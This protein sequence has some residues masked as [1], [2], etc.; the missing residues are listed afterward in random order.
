MTLTEFIAKWQKSTLTERA[1]AQSHFLELCRVLGQPEPSSD[2]TGENYA[3][4]KSVGKIGGKGSGGS[5]FA[6]VWLRDHFAWE[7]KGKRKNLADAYDQILQYREQLGNPPLLVVCDLNRFE[8]H[9]NFTAT[10]KQI[11]KF[12][13]ADLGKNEPTSDCRRPP[14][15]VLRALFEKPERLRPEHTT[16]YVTEEAAKTFGRLAQS[17]QG[18]GYEPHPISRFLIRVLFCLFAEDVGLL[19][20]RLFTTLIEKTRARPD[21]F[22]KRLASLFEAMSGGGSFGADDIKHF[23]GGL[24]TDASVLPLVRDDLTILAGCATLDWSSIEPSIFGTLFERS[25]DPAS[26]AQLGAHYTSR[27]DIEA[28]VE[29]V[30]MA[31]LRRRWAEVQ[32]EASVLAE[33]REAASGAQKTRHSAALGRLLQG[34]SE[35]LAAVRVLDPACGSGNFLYVALRALLDLEKDVITHALSLDAG[36]FF[37]RVGPEQMRGI[38]LNEYAHELAPITVWIG[39]IQ[40]LKDNGFGQPSEPILREMQTIQA[41]DAVL[42]YDAI[43]RPIEP[44]WPEADVIIGNPPFLG[45]KRMRSELGPDYSEN[46]RRLYEGRVP[47]GADLVTYWFERTRALVEEGKVQRAGLLSTNSIRSGSNRVVLERIKQSGDIFFAWSDRAWVL[48]GADVRVSMIGFDAGT[49]TERVLDGLPTEMINA[50]LSGQVDVTQARTLAENAR[51]VF[52]GMM[53]GGPFELDTAQAHAML[54]APTNVNGRPNSDVVRARLGGQDVTGRPRGGYVIDFGVDMTEANAALYEMPFEY[55]RTHVKPLRDQNRRESMKR[56]WWIH[57]E[58]RRGLRAALVGKSRCIVT[59]E[60]SKHRLFSWM[61][62]ATVPDHKLHVF[63]REDDYFFGVLH[64]RVHELWTLTQCSWMGVGNDPS[65]SSSRTFGT[66]PMPWPPGQE[67][68]TNPM[69]QAVAEAARALVERREAWLNPEGATAADLSKRTLTNLYNLCPSW[70]ENLHKTL[71]ASVLAAYG[72]LTDLSDRE[73]LEHL[74]ALNLSRS[75]AVHKA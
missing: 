21:E 62:T 58:P 35:E 57:G 70:L 45:D 31:P 43:G 75:L 52:L 44:V 7:Y 36:G 69:V 16:A 65:Y 55:V 12:T 29:P 11:F 61:D 10:A 9:T 40:W 54:S 6:D 32:V 33:K 73:L 27:A 59:P 41:G 67:A 42:A 51:L 2:P 18:C 25:L 38:E 50:D 4:E 49:E 56:R 5:G 60:V 47:G 14:L 3:F 64:S 48:D 53:K 30:L 26:R 34:F 19:P 1:A 15:D 20:D 37:P 68:P 24:F 63:A 23:N 46:L 22:S 8:V 74:L 66:F 17:L 39:Y 71:D 28:I 72:W 13:L